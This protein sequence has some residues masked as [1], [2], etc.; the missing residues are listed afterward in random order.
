MGHLAPVAR[1]GCTTAT[2]HCDVPLQGE[3][4]F[5]M[6]CFD[7]SQVRS[8][9]SG[10]SDQISTLLPRNPPQDSVLPSHHGSS[11]RFR[12]RLWLGN[13]SLVDHAPLRTLAR[14]CCLHVPTLG[15]LHQPGSTLNLCEAFLFSQSYNSE[16]LRQQLALPAPPAPF[17]TST[18]DSVTRIG[19]L[20]VM[21]IEY[22]AMHAPSS[23]TSSPSRP[24]ESGH[25]RPL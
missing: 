2:N 19:P 25:P 10:S 5:L 4:L 17:T 18:L 8:S 16:Q 3:H 9:N 13:A 14:M 24:I 21:Q 6:A 11:L 15:D 7:Y 1:R 22:G 20:Q 23:L 12:G